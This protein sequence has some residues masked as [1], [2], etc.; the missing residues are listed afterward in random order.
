MGNCIPGELC[1]V[2]LG[3]GVVCTGV[4]WPGPGLRCPLLTARRLVC[5]LSQSQ[6]ICEETV[7]MVASWRCENGVILT[8]IKRKKALKHY[9]STFGTKWQTNGADIF[10][11]T[12]PPP[13]C[14]P[15]CSCDISLALARGG[16]EWRRRCWQTARHHA[17]L[18]GLGHTIMQPA[19]TMGMETG[20][21]DQEY[22]VAAPIYWDQSLAWWAEG[23]NM[24]SD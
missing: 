11:C 3:L 16:R 5:I 4:C 23:S 12:G 9:F 1:F 13:V 19:Y 2:R 14:V 10:H 20:A 22:V 8:E 18:P 24:S 21:G 6:G 7:V 17:P 15:G